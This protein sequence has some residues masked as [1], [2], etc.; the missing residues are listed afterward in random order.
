MQWLISQKYS[1]IQQHNL[2][3]E[4]WKGPP[5]VHEAFLVQQTSLE[6]PL[7]RCCADCSSKHENSVYSDP[8][9]KAC[10]HNTRERFH[11]YSRHRP[12][13]NSC[14]IL[15][16]PT[17]GSRKARSLVTKSAFII[18]TKCTAKSH[19]QLPAGSMIAFMSGH[20]SGFT[21]NTHRCIN[22]LLLT[23]RRRQVKSTLCFLHHNTIKASKW[24]QLGTQCSQYIPSILFTTSTCCGPLQV[25]HQ[26]E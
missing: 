26:E 12:K 18:K 9:I 2:V 3:T 19:L 11:I 23:W 24:N 13:S 5:T 21:F 8:C 17:R 14:A 1:D 7:T 4:V 22:Q 10:L 15:Q 6:E 25:H 16:A 20:Q